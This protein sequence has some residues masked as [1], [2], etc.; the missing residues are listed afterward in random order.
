MTQHNP[1]GSSSFFRSLPDHIAPDLPSHAAKPF[2]VRR[3]LIAFIQSLLALAL[4]FMVAQVYDRVIPTQSYSTLALLCLG[5]GIAILL[6]GFLRLLRIRFDDRQEFTALI[7]LPCSGIF[8]LAIFFLGDVLVLA[9]LLLLV[10]F[11]LLAY[12]TQKHARSTATLLGAMFSQ[13]ALILTALAGSILVING[14][15]SLGALSACILLAGLTLSSV[16]RAMVFWLQRQEPLAFALSART[17]DTLPPAPNGHILLDDVSFAYQ[18]DRPILEHV[19]FEVQSGETIA[20][21]GATGAGKSTLLQV[22]AGTLAPTN[23]KVQIDGI[24]PVAY[25]PALLETYMGYLPQQGTIFNGTLL[26]NLAG[27]STAETDITKARNMAQEFGLQ[28]LI[29]QLPEGELTM[30]TDDM[31]AQLPPGITQRIALARAL[32]SSPT[33]MLFDDADQ[34]LDKE[35]YNKLFRLM[36]RYKG[37]HTIIMATQ[38]QN[39]LSLCDRAYRLENGRLIQD[40][41]RG[42]A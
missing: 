12:M 37:Q 23:G 24:A 25:G 39:F 8:L 9:P 16:E 7:D 21:T 38:D 4:P 2:N 19:T 31:A 18:P 29:E 13:L 40:A 22:L 30:L 11:S 28:E 32:K 34:T 41:K 36:G 17:T 6:Q 5:V 42:M 35:G 3:F 10:L 1:A 26:E 15:L 14:Q 20:I 27:F 33:I